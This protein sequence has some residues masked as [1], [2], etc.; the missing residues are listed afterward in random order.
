MSETL[1]PGDFERALALGLNRTPLKSGEET[2]LATLALLAQQKRHRRT[3]GIT[4]AAVE[5]RL[6][7]D[8]RPIMPDAARKPLTRLATSL[9]KDGWSFVGDA[10]FNRLDACGVRLHPF[11]L[12]RLEHLLRACPERIGSAERVWLSLRSPAQDATP[13]DTP[14]DNEAEWRLL[15]KAQKASALRQLRAKDAGKGR[16]W[17]ENNIANIPADVRAALVEALEVGLSTAD[18]P[19]LERLAEEDRAISVR[20]AATDLLAATRGSA[21]YEAKLAIAATL[22]EM[23]RT[24]LGR[25]TVK[26]KSDELA[27]LIELPKNA[28][29]GARTLAETEALHRAFR[30]LAFSDIAKALAIAPGDLAAAL[31]SD[32]GLAA[33]LAVAALHEG[34]AGIATKLMPHIA[35]LGL[36]EVIGRFGPLLLNLPQATR[37][38]TLEALTPSILQWRWSHELLWLNR[39]AG[40]V[41]SDGLARK[42][43]SNG[44]WKSPEATSVD[45]TTYAAFA[46]LL[47]HGRDADFAAAIA[48]LPRKEI[49]AAFE[50]IAF[51]T[52]LA[53]SPK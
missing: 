40:G 12:P 50:F 45:A 30:N 11:D 8:P 43:L 16:S 39:M 52:A 37:M 19:L 24:I 23:S 22:I 28:T 48:D 1:I 49:A 3:P 29:T 15:P 32:D 38:A 27:K 44:V 51:T 9:P 2:A 6:H 46:A 34:D 4:T 5:T 13:A 10:V 20:D 53:S 25:R 14:A 18:T 31:G 17:V 47:P 7:H 33:I 41:V 36:S 21:A 35:K 42:L 26:L